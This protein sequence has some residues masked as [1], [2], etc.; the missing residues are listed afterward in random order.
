MVAAI[1][2]S[3]ESTAIPPGDA[4]VQNSLEDESSEH[5]LPPLVYQLV[6]PEE[7]GA[8]VLMSAVVAGSSSGLP[9]TVHVLAA[10]QTRTLLPGAASALKKASPT[11]HAGG[12]LEPVLNGLVETDAE[13]STFFP[14]CLRSTFVCPETIKANP[15]VSIN[16]ITLDELPRHLC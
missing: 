11:E 12:M 10:V 3:N 14:C 9:S 13:K 15:T 5:S 16:P 4:P 2:P 6:R 7:G 8:G 1:D